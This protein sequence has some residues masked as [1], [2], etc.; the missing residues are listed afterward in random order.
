MMCRC[1]RWPVTEWVEVM[2]GGQQQ[3]NV[4][5]EGIVGLC[6]VCAIWQREYMSVPAAEVDA[7]LWQRVEALVA[8]KEQELRVNPPE[9]GVFRCGCGATLKLN[10][11]V[12]TSTGLSSALVREGW[13]SS[14]A[15]GRFW[16]AECGPKLR[17]VGRKRRAA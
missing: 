1:K 16:C 10:I 11:K 5:S 7:R 2:I 15:T 9:A 4:F 3:Q 14:N 13:H 8:A 6:P 12:S 17:T